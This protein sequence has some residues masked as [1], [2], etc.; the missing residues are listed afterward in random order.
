MATQTAAEEKVE[1]H[2]SAIQ[3]LT[4]RVEET[5]TSPMKE[6]VKIVKPPPEPEGRYT[7]DEAAKM[8]TRRCKHTVL[9]K[10]E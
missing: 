7:R 4:S 5:G 8:I 2:D 1:T 6:R 3:T 9:R 10:R